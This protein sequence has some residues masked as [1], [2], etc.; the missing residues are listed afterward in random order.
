MTWF[1]E[2]LPLDLFTVPLYQLIFTWLCR[3]VVFLYSYP[4]HAYHTDFI[5]F[6]AVNR[7]FS[8]TTLVIW[9]LLAVI[10]IVLVKLSTLTAALTS[11]TNT[12]ADAS[13]SETTNPSDRS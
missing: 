10:V 11:K 5:I 4:I 9:S 13:T 2:Q 8:L 3:L 6:T 12:S 7:F 1:F